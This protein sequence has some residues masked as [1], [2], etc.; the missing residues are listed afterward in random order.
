M[1]D[2]VLGEWLEEA[3]GSPALHIH[4]HVSGGLVFGSARL[5]DR[6]FRHHLPLALRT[7]LHG[8]RAFIAPQERL[9]DAPLIVHFHARKKKWNRAES[10]GEV[11]GYSG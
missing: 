3:N 5:R 4:L 9:L 11:R 6:I 7:I 10:W 1:R 2:E 8:D